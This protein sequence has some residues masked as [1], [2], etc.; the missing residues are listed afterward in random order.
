MCGVS[1]V[2]SERLACDKRGFFGQEVRNRSGD[3]FGI[4]RPTHEMA[5]RDRRE[6]V[7]EWPT[8]SAWDPRRLHTL[9]VRMEHD[10][11][12]IREAVPA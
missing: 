12:T 7:A 2:D 1:A 11:K 10:S 4:A 5:F 6:G 3:L 9:E 8:E